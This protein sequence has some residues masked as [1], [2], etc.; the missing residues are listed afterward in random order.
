VQLR[1][2][3]AG[4]RAS[5]LQHD[6]GASGGVHLPA[7]HGEHDRE[8]AD[9]VPRHQ[10]GGHARSVHHRAYDEGP[11]GPHRA[12]PTS[13]ASRVPTTRGLS[14]TNGTAT[15]TLTPT[16]PSCPRRTKCRW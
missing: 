3:R 4:H 11:R 10:R 13:K 6:G 14:T 12:S 15:M 1:G 16:C 5:H 8:R 7:A 2:L 9:V